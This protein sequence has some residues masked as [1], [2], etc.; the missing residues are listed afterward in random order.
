MTFELKVHNNIIIKI[1]KLLNTN[2]VGT[3]LIMKI[4][5]KIIFNNYLILKC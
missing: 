5:I 2:N 4:V 1:T 3:C